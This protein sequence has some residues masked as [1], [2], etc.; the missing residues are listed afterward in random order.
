MV[1][2][3][4]NDL[5]EDGGV[6]VG[7]RDDLLL[8]LVHPEVLQHRLDGH[9]LLGDLHVHGEDLPVGGLKLDRGH[10]GGEVCGRGLE[11]KFGKYGCAMWG[12]N[13]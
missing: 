8:V 6:D 3:P 12:N 7:Q 13:G 4:L 10:L 1:R 5:L 9:R 2:G 11:V